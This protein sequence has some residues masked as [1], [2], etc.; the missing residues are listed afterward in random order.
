MF[1]CIYIFVWPVVFNS[2]GICIQVQLLGHMIILFAKLFWR[3]RTILYSHQQCLKDSNFS[4]S[5]PILV[6]VCLFYDRHP[7]GYEMIS[8]C[9]FVLHFPNDELS[10]FS[11]VF[12]LWRNVSIQI[13]HP[14]LVCLSFFVEFC[15]LFIYSGYKILFRYIICKFLLFCG[16]SFHF[17]D[18]VLWRTQNT[19]VFNL[20]FFFYFFIHPGA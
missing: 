8:F 11:F 4:V 6:T 19:K 10:T 3:G 18:S 1:I 15:T 2:L 20:F 9:G 12:L 7:T 13:I 14:F 16:L 5:S 17:L